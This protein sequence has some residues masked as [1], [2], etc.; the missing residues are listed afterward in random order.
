MMS[1][2]VIQLTYWLPLPTQPPSPMRNG[3]SIVP[4]A[5]PV[6][7]STTPVRM[8]TTRIPARAAT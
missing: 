2:R 5:P 8:F 4:S 7:V 3:G 6:G 1:S